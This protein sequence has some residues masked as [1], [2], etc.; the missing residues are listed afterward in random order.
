VKVHVYGCHEKQRVS[1]HVAPRAKFTCRHCG[2]SA[3]TLATHCDH[4]A[5]HHSPQSELIRV[6]T[7][8]YCDCHSDN[9]EVLEDHV[10]LCHPTK[11]MKFEVQQ[12]NVS[13]LQASTLCMSNVWDVTEFKFEFY[14]FRRLFS[15]ICQFLRQI[16]VK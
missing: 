14:E 15:K 11:D 4:L 13:Y 8:V 7:C 1:Q 16:S 10:A 2:T 5:H 9:I 6:F 12:S 3:D